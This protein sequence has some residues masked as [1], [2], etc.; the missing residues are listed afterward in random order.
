[1]YVNFVHTYLFQWILRFCFS[2]WSLLLYIFL[3]SSNMSLFYSTMID[4]DCKYQRYAT[5][6]M[7]L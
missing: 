5:D 1:M 3:I 2:P 6:S 7:Y 4:D